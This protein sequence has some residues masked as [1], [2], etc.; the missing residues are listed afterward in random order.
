M[1]GRGGT[2]PDL[3]ADVQINI[4]T[5]PGNQNPTLSLGADNL[6]PAQNIVVTFTATANDPNGDALAYHWDFGDKTFGPNAATATKSWSTTGSKTVKCIVS[7][8]KGGTATQTIN[9]TVVNLPVVTVTAS[10]ASATETPGNPGEF[11][12]TRTGS[13]S[14]ALNVAYTMSGSAANGADYTALSGTAT[15]AAG[16]TNVKIAVLPADDGYSE[17]PETV[18]LNLPGSTAYAA[19]NPSNATV[20]IADNEPAPPSVRFTA[21]SASGLESVAN[22]VLPVTLTASSAFNIM[23]D[24]AVSG[25]TASSGGDFTLASGTLNFAPGETSKE[26][27]FTV[28][29][30]AVYELDETIVV[31]L[32][33]PLNVL[34]G[35]PSTHT[36]TITND[37]DPPPPG[38]GKGLF[39][40]YFDNSDLSAPVL[41]RIDETVNFDWGT[42]SPDAGIGVDTFSARWSGFV[43]PQFTETYTFYVRTD[44]GVRLWVND[45]LLS[46]Y[47]VNQGPTEHSST[48]ALTAGVK[49]SIRME[50]FENAGGAVA[51]L[52]WS[53]PTT[54]KAIIPKAQLFPPN[55]APA[56]GSAISAAP[57][58]VP[59]GGEVLFTAAA[60]D[61]DGDALNYAW[62]FGDGTFDSGTSVSHAYAAAG[63]FTATVTVSDGYDG[64]ASSSVGITVQLPPNGKKGGG[65]DPG[66]GSTPPGTGSDEDFNGDGVPNS[67]DPDDDGDGIPDA[68]D[69]EPFSK[70]PM[71]VTKLQGA[72]KFNA[73][74]KDAVSV[75]GII[76][77]LPALFTPLDVRASV[78]VGGAL[79]EFVLDAKGRAK[80]AGGS[81][82]LKT[83][84]VRNKTTKAKEFLGGAAPF[85]IK[86][87]KGTFSDDWEDEGADPD[88]DANKAPMEIM[89][90]LP[91]GGRVY[92]AT[93]TTVYSA[94]AQ[95]GGRFKK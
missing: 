54:A 70:L 76:P 28:A 29:N 71:T 91:F 90:D 3:W 59:V 25:G 19:G 13:T 92:T 32:S 39:A 9:V 74:G 7:D 37:D 41:S 31:A 85:R 72:M 81:F 11:T 33:N 84:L 35:A 48:V 86:L 88:A 94:K 52:S 20:T 55:S 89:V 15:I 42:N 53:S 27:A 17:G 2:S 40:E 16:S 77:E 95:K 4:G 75:Q 73:A 79:V 63:I 50:Y 66:G 38:N 18:I 61:A 56:F 64:S 23:V 14:A 60:S 82:M 57:N 68:L 30:D 34:L 43:L 49:T 1:T 46:D 8:M 80:N 6:S 44:D 65:N 78:N 67:Q 12:L 47:W 22:V 58:P 36:Y 10:D 45:Q 62:D 93:V 5:F 87:S 26:I 24:Y 83:K 21:A 69:I 51:Q